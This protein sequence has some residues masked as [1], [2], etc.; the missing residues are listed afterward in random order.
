MC[1]TKTPSCVSISA[2]DAEGVSL[3]EDR[4]QS[5][6]LRLAGLA[7]GLENQSRNFSK[8]IR[9][10]SP[11]PMIPVVSRRTRNSAGRTWTCSRP[12]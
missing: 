4:R 8:G 12:Q 2:A 6:L 10:A 3:L 7:S 1:E 9:A 11:V 5:E